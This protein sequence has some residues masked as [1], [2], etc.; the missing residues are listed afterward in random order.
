M[1]QSF[2]AIKIDGCISIIGFLGGGEAESPSILNV[3][4]NVCTVRG[5]LVGSRMQFEEMNRAIEVNNIK[6][7][8]DKTVFEL[9]QLKDAYQYLVSLLH[10][11]S[12]NA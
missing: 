12:W 6:P 9:E 1:E 11:A 7:V 2:K 4:R 10:I 8:V 3:L 5:A